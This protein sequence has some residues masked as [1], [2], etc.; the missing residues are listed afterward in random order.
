MVG[1]SV[2]GNVAPEKVKA[3]PVKLAALTVTGEVPVEVSV[4]DRVAVV[5]TGSSPKF[6]AVVLTVSTGLEGL[7]PVP[8]RLTAIV[9]AAEELLEMVMV[10]LSVPVAV[11]SKLT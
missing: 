3:V 5:P 4:T 6:S 7:V 9:A 2:T 1:L 8:L 10:P 11:G